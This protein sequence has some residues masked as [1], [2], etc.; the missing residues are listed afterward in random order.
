M[1][2]AMNLGLDLAPKP[3]KVAPA[4]AP[5]PTAWDAASGL[6]G[7]EGRSFGE[8]EKLAAGGTVN[9]W[10]WDGSAK[11]N[12]WVDGWL[13]VR[14]V[15]RSISPPWGQFDFARLSA[16]TRHGAYVW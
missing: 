2:R 8:I 13:Q 5:A 1:L 6:P 3:A 4:P 16:R 9:F 14:G 12:A 10:M 11:I 15:G 7:F